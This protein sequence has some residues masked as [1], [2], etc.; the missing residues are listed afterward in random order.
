MV[1]EEEFEDATANLDGT[2]S[3]TVDVADTA[4]ENGAQGGA[5]RG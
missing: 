1:E 4:V 5:W 2:P 3:M